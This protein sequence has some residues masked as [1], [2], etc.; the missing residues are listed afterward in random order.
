MT[1]LLKLVAAFICTFVSTMPASAQSPNLLVNGDFEAIYVPLYGDNLNTIISPWLQ[2]A[3]ID[4]GSS[5]RKISIVKTDGPG[6]NPEIA[7]AQ[8]WSGAPS[9]ADVPV[10]DASNNAVG[11]FMR[12]HSRWQGFRFGQRIATPYRGCVSFGASLATSKT[13][14]LV[15]RVEKVQ[16][17]ALAILAG[18]S[19]TY[20]SNVP[21]SDPAWGNGSQTLHRSVPL[22]VNA[23][24]QD[25]S[26]FMS[27]QAGV[28]YNFKYVL[29]SGA[30]MDNA[31]VRYVD[32][33]ICPSLAGVP[34]PPIVASAPGLNV[35]QTSIQKICEAP[36]QGTH[37]GKL[38]QHWACRINVNAA[39]APFAGT[40]TVNDAPS[41]NTGNTATQIISMTSSETGVDCSAG[42]S[43][44]VDG[45][46]FDGSGVIDVQTFV[47]TTGQA[48]SYTA[49]NCTSG[50]YSNDAEPVSI[51]G[52]CVQASFNPR[53]STTKICDPVVPVASG[54]MTLNCRISVSGSNL[55]T[56]GFITVIDLFGAPAP[57]SANVVGSMMNV[58][59]NE[60]WSC[61]DASSS[62]NAGACELSTLDLFNAG[63][64]STINVGFKFEVGPD[65]Q[66]VFNCGPGQI[67]PTSVLEA[68]SKQK[69]S[70]R[71]ALTANNL[72][73]Y[74][75]AID[76][77]RYKEPPLLPLKE[78]KVQ[79]ECGRPE[80][81]EIK[82][83]RGL[84]WK[85]KITVDAS[86]VP[87]AGSFTLNED[88][89]SFS[90][91][92]PGNIVSLDPV[93]PDWQCQQNLPAQTSSCTIAGTD[94]S[95]SGSE[96]V[97]VTL[98]VLTGEKPIDWKNCV[99]GTSQPLKGEKGET[100]E[101]GGNC[102][103]MSWTPTGD[104]GKETTFKVEKICEPRGKRHV[105]KPGTWFQPYRCAIT[106][107]TNGV[108]FS[109]PIYVQDSL[110]VGGQ[111]GD[112]LI[113]GLSSTDP[114]TCNPGPYSSTNYAGC[115]IMGAQ[116]PHNPGISTINVV[117]VVNSSTAELGIENCGIL[118]TINTD[119]GKPTPIGESCTTIAE[120]IDDEPKPF[121]NVNKFC[122]Q[123]TRN[124]ATWN[125]AC[126][127]TIS[128]GNMPAGTPIRLS[129]EMLSIPR[130]TASSGQFQSSIAQCGGGNTGNGVLAACDLSSDDLANGPITFNYTGAF[131]S[132][133][134][135][136]QQ[137]T[138]QNCA[139]ADAPG[140][141]LH[142]PTGGNGK[143][144]VPL[145]LG[146]PVVLDEVADPIITPPKVKRNL[147][148][149]KKQAGVCVTG[150]PCR[151]DFTISNTG[152]VPTNVPQ[153]V[154]EMSPSTGV[155]VHSASSPFACTASGGR[156]I[157]DP[158]AS[159]S[160][161]PGDNH[162]MN[163]Q[164]VLPVGADGEYRNCA[165]LQWQPYAV[166]FSER[167]VRSIQQALA[168][169]G[170]NP[171]VI[172]GAM[173]RNTREAIR[174]FQSK[175]GL[176]PTGELNERSASLLFGTLAQA[177]F[178]DDNKEDDK[179]C[180]G[181]EYKEGEPQHSKAKSRLDEHNTYKSLLVTFHRQY[182]SSEHDR[183]RTRRVHNRAKSEEQSHD[184]RISRF[185]EKFR[186]NQHDARTT[187]VREEHRRSQS[188]LD[189]FH[190]KYR[191]RQHD[192][193][194]TKLAHDRRKSELDNHDKRLSRFHGRF[195]SSEHNA[196]TTRRIETHS[197]SRSAIEIFHRKYKSNQHDG[198]RTRLRHDRARSRL[199]E[200]HRKYK[201]NQHDRKVTRV[202]HD[203]RR[204][205]E[206]NH[207]KR[208]SRFHGR[209]KS[210][211]HN[212]RT[213]RRIE[214]H[215]K[216][217]SAIET[218]HR[219]Y[220]SN[221]HDGRRTR[222]RHDRLRS[223]LVE[224][225]KKFKSSQHDGRRTII[226]RTDKP[227]PRPALK[228]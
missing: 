170:F 76:V 61:I 220:K 213:T 143:A 206:Q 33:S 88:A 186:S 44:S 81:G 91:P 208:I 226:R 10:L 80:E 109:G 157:C 209:Y 36:T 106:V 17:G 82:D 192:R 104:P 13:P 224:V 160:L 123:P 51:N 115:W 150:S 48:E 60:N 155:T 12:V 216:S 70:N 110:T 87:F 190:R 197:K 67:T 35:D 127:V 132:Q 130:Y 56:D 24:W 140:L 52:N 120:E 171:G 42:Q 112:Q 107:T 55:P 149:T 161:A 202:V 195:K 162:S 41:Q 193:K 3:D 29:Y 128:G 221:Q 225:H 32:N 40:L 223:R 191:S 119:T 101:F 73:D 84:I 66:Q 184:K 46:T 8:Y 118:N 114:W 165:I 71:S 126:V 204:S 169:K 19:S 217:Q 6:A 172:D 9:L 4:S 200:F 164:L 159:I 99:S 228:P 103:G 163:V 111:P 124:G 62:Q 54:P 94:F 25:V 50:S 5:F 122:A 187:K 95:T 57:G 158:T 142:A 138:A 28:T 93:N 203:R 152:N 43:C 64:S 30:S 47:E 102:E 53:D 185:H 16:A 15:L 136:G 20:V 145:T 188:R 218:F 219:K 201:S 89:S 1:N 211:E 182:S 38:G 69:S 31:F 175:N 134:V 49:K 214:S 65:T 212:R 77:P 215:S 74:C 129:D 18:Q 68:L 154:D 27:V 180:I 198:R 194:V 133:T 210:R 196:R 131:L 148:I 26:A 11:N 83:E 173:G 227:A 137:R 72:P 146:T 141:N 37:N 135:L 205:L 108:P 168:N 100:R 22:Q 179:S 178:G 75:T 222:L 199:L 2:S 45:A 156:I 139:F 183:R 166:G 98:F 153:I 116:Y 21:V 189:E 167:S 97:E 34:N 92:T 174:S 207:D 113:T 79:K 85:C 105:L 7:A 23:G 176:V 121:L 86:P 177:K 125:V 181:V 39:P 144:C 147:A 96:T 78:A 58:T 90:G 14:Y 63:G 59:S 117:M 151:F